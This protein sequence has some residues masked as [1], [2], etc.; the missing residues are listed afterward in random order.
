MVAKGFARIHWQNLVNFGV[1]PLTFAK[2]ADYDDLE[3]GDVIV[4]ARLRETVG[5]SNTMTVS[6]KGKHKLKLQHQLSPRQVNVLL[7][8][9]LINWMRER[10]AA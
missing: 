1:L 8:G 2:P 10:H 3:Q 5:N 6:V 7:A 9:G 4:L